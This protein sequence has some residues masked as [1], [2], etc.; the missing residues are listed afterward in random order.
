MYCKMQRDPHRVKNIFK[1]RG[2]SKFPYWGLTMEVDSVTA[3]DLTGALQNQA[4]N[5]SLGVSS[6]I[7]K[8]ELNRTELN[9][10]LV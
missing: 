5:P 10:S 7:L 1:H 8:A 4:F 6:M 2:K 9:R 3:Q